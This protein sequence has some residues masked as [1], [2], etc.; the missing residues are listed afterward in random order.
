M[1]NFDWVS[2]LAGGALTSL[3]STVVRKMPEPTAVGGNV[4]YKWIYDVVQAVF[5]NPDISGLFKKRGTTE[6]GK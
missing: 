6:P 3:I 4:W 1:T 5:A 2:L